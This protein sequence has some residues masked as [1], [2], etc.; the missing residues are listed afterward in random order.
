MRSNEHPIAQSVPGCFLV[1]F[2]FI[3]V[4]I[5]TIFH[6]QLSPSL[7]CRCTCLFSHGEGERVR[8]ADWYSWRLALQNWDCWALVFFY[9][10]TE[11]SGTWLDWHSSG[12]CSEWLVKATLLLREAFSFSFRHSILL[13]YIDSS[14]QPRVYLILTMVCLMF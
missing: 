8:S 9:P 2:F 1:W 5:I 12:D 6:K 3:F 14:S 13:I 4:I 10:A 11:L 7:L